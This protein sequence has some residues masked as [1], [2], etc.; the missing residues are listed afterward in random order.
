MYRVRTLIQWSYVCIELELSFNRA[1]SLNSH[2][3]Q[4]A[5]CFVFATILWMALPNNGGL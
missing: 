1:M 3:E 2:A 5:Q 4:E